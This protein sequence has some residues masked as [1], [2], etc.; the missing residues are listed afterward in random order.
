MT[1]TVKLIALGVL[2]I[3]LFGLS[4]GC[5]KVWVPAS[6]WFSGDPRWWIIIE[7]RLPRAVLGLALGATLGLSGAV[8]QGYLRNPLADP[9]VVG[10]SSVAALAAVAAIV[11][12][13]GSGPAIFA[14]AMLGAG[15]AVAL[16][17]ALTWRSPSA[18]T[19]ILAGTVLSSLAGALTAF[20]ISIAPNP[21]TVAEVID[22][23]MG[24][25]TD[26]GWDDVTLALPPMAVGAVLL[27]LTGRSLD[28]L[29]L[30]EAAARSLGTRMGRVRL[31]V[32]LGTG[33]VVGAGVAV[34]G[35]IGFIGL[36]V[37]HLLR[38][39]FGHR[40]SA[41]LLPSALGGAALVLAADSLVRL[42][43]GAGE[44][45]LGVAMAMIGAPFFLGLLVKER[46]RAWI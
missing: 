35:V 34:T 26:R 32:V 6:A 5:G 3:L 45:R 24:A 17:A 13:L 36:V 41:L 31:L 46:G 10:V 14:A 43:P 29:A 30:G 11:F 25:L 22:W 33:L 12:G 37:P 16:L 39:I 4:L 21:Y 7:L 9:A 1:R 23:I 15:G 27:L 28:A 19:F 18:I 2:V 38:P 44:V 40:P 20:L 8:L 42:A